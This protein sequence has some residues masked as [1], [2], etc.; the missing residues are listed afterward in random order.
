[1]SAVFRGDGRDAIEVS[2]SWVLAE[3]VRDATH[4]LAQGGNAE[5]VRGR[6]LDIGFNSR[7]DG[8]LAV[9]GETIPL[10]FM[11]QLVALEIELWLSI[12]PAFS[13]FPSSAEKRGRESTADKCPT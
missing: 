7:L 13:A 10:E 12:Y 5:S 6:V 8:T 4:W 1:M 3:Q 11:K 2:A 9:Q